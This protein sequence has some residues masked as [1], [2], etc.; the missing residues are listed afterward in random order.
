MNA[1][2]IKAA[3]TVAA[4]LFAGCA[5]AAGPLAPAQEARLA[6]A[7]AALELVRVAYSRPVA[8][9]IRV[10]TRRLGDPPD[11]ST[12]SFALTGACLTQQSTTGPS[13]P[14]RPRI[15]S[16]AMWG[17]RSAGAT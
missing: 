1:R 2:R 12:G 7:R 13:P 15:G 10:V 5:S 11:T 16:G 14:T 9:E 8:P 4:L 17:T 3:V 6:E